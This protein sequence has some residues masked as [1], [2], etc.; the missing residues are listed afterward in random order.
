MMWL[1]IPAVVLV[2]LFILVLCWLFFKDYTCCPCRRRN[3]SPEP[4]LPTH[5]TSSFP[6][7]LYPP[8]APIQ[9]PITPGGSPHLQLAHADLSASDR[10]PLIPSEDDDSIF[11]I[12][13][14]VLAPL[15][16]PR[17]H[18]PTPSS[19]R[20]VSRRLPSISFGPEPEL[21]PKANTQSTVTA[22]LKHDPALPSERT[23]T[24]E[25]KLS[26][27]E[28]QGRFMAPS[29]DFVT[30][31]SKDISTTEPK[32]SR[33]ETQGRFMA[34]SLDFVTPLSKDI[35]TTEP[36]LSRDETQGRFMALSQDFA[37]PL[38]KDISTTE[39]QLP[40]AK[41]QGL[42]N[43]FSEDFATPLSKDISKTE[44]QLPKDTKQTNFSED[45]PNLPSKHSL[46]TETQ[47]S[48]TKKQR[49]GKAPTQHIPKQSS[50]PASKTQPL[51]VCNLPK[52][53]DFVNIKTQV[54][55]KP[56][57]WYENE[58]QPFK[59]KASNYNLVSPGDS[60][61]LHLKFAD[62]SFR[63]VLKVDNDGIVTLDLH[64]MTVHEA[65]QMVSDFT[66]D[67][68]DE[69]HR[70]RII[71]GRGIRS[72]GGIPKIKPAVKDFLESE[73]FKFCEIHSGGC[74]EVLL[75]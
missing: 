26:R 11:T 21:P 56:T 37:T 30:P 61:H 69:Q 10:E 65:V 17:L 66:D 7:D 33:D 72:K 74:L 75:S 51:D 34:A 39:P 71:T 6:H 44:P 54:T 50:R 15:P 5:H 45:F 58:S 36:K 48:K 49:T 67:F 53:S 35:S 29:L 70:V 22:T 64:N 38:S 3:R 73:G 60:P 42:F 40:N 32:L 59:K 52:L 23:S 63:D 41:K 55:I 47:T 16:V 46:A 8:S 31:L 18:F 62:L 68:K 19:H 43:N 1:W 27:D 24:A 2:A 20:H 13:N 57:V 12:S 25:P 14:S 4:V 9:Y 28:T